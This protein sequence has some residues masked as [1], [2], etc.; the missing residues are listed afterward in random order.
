VL[1]Q[2]IES[3]VVSRARD[4]MIVGVTPGFCAMAGFD[5][6]DVIGRTSVELDMWVDRDRR[7]QMLAE[8][9]IAGTVRDFEGDLRTQAGKLVRCRIS[10]QL[11]EHEDEPHIFMVLRDVTSEYATQRRLREAEQRYRTLVEHLPAATYVDAVDGTPLYASPQIERIYGCTHE[12][13]SRPRRSTVPPCGIT[14]AWTLRSSA[15][16]WPAACSS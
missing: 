8:L 9:E 13:S 14:S 11:I 2:G 15:Y 1:E 7:A 4:G 10:A 16:T 3:I 6:G 5:P 12:R